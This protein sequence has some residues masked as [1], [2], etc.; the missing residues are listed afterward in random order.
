[1]DESSGNSCG[2]SKNAFKRQ[3]KAEKRLQN[4]SEWVKKK[5]RQRKESL[6]RRNA[7]LR[8][9]G[10]IIWRIFFISCICLGLEVPKRF[11]SGDEK[12]SSGTVIFDL[13]FES[14]MLQKVDHFIILPIEVF[15]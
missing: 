13:D 12:P 11:K 14:L 7:E 5:R 4:K 3:I 9:R 15:V 2:L 10:I 8:E 6:K 1:M